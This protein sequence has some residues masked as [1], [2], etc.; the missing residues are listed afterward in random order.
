LARSERYVERESQAAPADGERPAAMLSGE[1]ISWEELRPAL[2]EAAGGRVLEEVALDRLLAKEAAASGLMIGEAQ[3]EAE[4]R[5]LAASLGADGR[6]P[7]R[8]AELLDRVRRSRGL[9]DARFGALLK[10]NATLRALVAPTVQVTE[11]SAR[12]A[13][14]MRYGERIRTRLITTATL[15]DAQGALN[16]V[17]AGEPFG[18]VAAQMSTD[19]SAARGGMIEPVH[20]SDASYPAALRQALLD[21]RD[22]ELAGPV[23]LEQSHAIALREGV[24]R[25]AAAPGF[26][27]MRAEMEVESRQSQERLQMDRLARR[28]LDGVGLTPLDR[29]LDWSW[30]AFRGR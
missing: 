23:A 12:Q 13:Y 6:D 30:R 5:L 28:M 7:V 27:S 11:D 20:P 19:V 24:V 15:Q 29:S 8:E 2:A 10:R 16:R 26:E 22:G 14:E 4:R 17:R 18:E 3:I 1:P 9:G 25:D 21:A